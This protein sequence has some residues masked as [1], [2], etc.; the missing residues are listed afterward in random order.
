MAGPDGLAGE[1]AYDT[2]DL[3]SILGITKRQ[4]ENPQSCVYTIKHMQHLK[5]LTLQVNDKLL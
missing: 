4:R 3:N 1:I 5:I 2:D